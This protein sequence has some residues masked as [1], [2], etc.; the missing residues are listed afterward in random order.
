MKAAVFHGGRDIRVEVLPDPAPGPG[1]ALIRIGA[2]GICGSD[3]HGWRGESPWP[4]RTPHL[5]GHELA[6]EIAAVGPGVHG[7]EVGA[8]VGIEPEH[9]RGC[10]RC[11]WCLAGDSHLC[12]TR[13]GRGADG[14][15]HRSHGFAE[16]DVCVSAHIHPLPEGVSIDAASI[17]DCYACAVHAVH[18]APVRLQSNVVVIGTGAIGMTVGQVALADG[19]GR[20]V[21]VGTRPGPL[22]VAVRAGAASE[23]VAASEGD[24]VE[25]VL[26]RTGGGADLVFETVGGGGPSFEQ[27]IAMARPGGQVC[28]LGVFTTPPA[29]D[30]RAAYGKEL[31]LRWSNSYARWEGVS[32]YEIALGLLA[33]GRLDAAPLIT[34]H[35][36]LARIQ[37]GFQ[38]AADKRTSGAIKVLV[39]P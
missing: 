13:G 10:G 32:E 11:R 4:R 7:L 37:E 2:A 35:F 12:P 36:P 29:L 34:H 1:E 17:L 3:L 39:H 33:G 30:V 23:G 16:Y 6:G 25:A 15:G 26:E 21:M 27:A 38:A 24:P 5:D 22:E 14:G 31:D 20:V 9:L 18:R 8:R 28:I 19:A